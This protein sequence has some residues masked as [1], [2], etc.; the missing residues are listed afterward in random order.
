MKKKKN[1]LCGFELETF[2][3]KVTVKNLRTK[4]LF[5]R[6]ENKIYIPSNTAFKEFESKPKTPRC[7]TIGM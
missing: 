3:I 2:G 6:G 7:V 5:T 1:T 4:N